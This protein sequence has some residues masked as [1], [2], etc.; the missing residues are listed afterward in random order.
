MISCKFDHV[1]LRTPAPYED[2]EFFERV[3][4]ARCERATSATGAPRVSM[5]IGGQTVLIA[6]AAPSAS[7]PPEGGHIGIDHIALEVDD[8][9]K[10]V[11]EL[12]GHGVTFVVQPNQV[13]PGLRIAIFVTLSGVKV[14]LLQRD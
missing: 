6:P 3:L 9:D 4:G 14:E 1:H 8:L 13:R 12:A 5:Q 10:A 2:A 7:A 11:D